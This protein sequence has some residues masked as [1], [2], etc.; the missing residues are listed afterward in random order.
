MINVGKCVGKASGDGRKS[1]DVSQLRTKTS[2]GATFVQPFFL[3]AI[4]LENRR[5]CAKLIGEQSVIFPAAGRAVVGD[6]VGRPRYTPFCNLNRDSC[7]VFYVD[8][9]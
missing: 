5:R 3:F 8:Q 7:S 4:E 9:I 2:I 1:Q 6:Q